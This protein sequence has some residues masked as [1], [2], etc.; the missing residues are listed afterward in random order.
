MD[1]TE[2]NQETK[3]LGLGIGALVIFLGVLA[4]AI[5]FDI[6]QAFKL[7]WLTAS[8]VPAVKQNGETKAIVPV[9]PPM[10]PLVAASANP[11]GL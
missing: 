9:R 10:L 5:H 7:G 6:T 11:T 8:G 4:P 2:W 3:L 1:I